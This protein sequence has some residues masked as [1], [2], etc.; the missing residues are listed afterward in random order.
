MVKGVSIKFAG[1]EETIPKLLKL[2]GFDTEMK[3]HARIVLKPNLVNGIKTGST[4]PEFTEQVLKF[5]MTNKNPGTEVYIAE[6]CDGFD[7]EEI[8]DDFG[9][10]SLS[11]KYGVGLIDL[12]NSETEII[13]DDGFLRFDEIYYPGILQ[14]AFIISLPCLRDDDETEIAGSLANMVGCFPSSKYKG[15]FSKNKSKIRKW[16]I[17]YAIHDI[18]KCKMPDFAI[19]DASDR[20]FI[21]AGKPLDMDKQAAKLLGREWNSVSH[22]KLIDESFLSSSIDK[23]KSE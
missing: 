9:Y 22:L 2:I 16:P 11:E 5:I 3:K 6:G 21:L 10:R 14:N 12:N 7:T 13:E 20:G 17:K 23:D 4:S 19:I 18:L 8:F 1:Y 15:F